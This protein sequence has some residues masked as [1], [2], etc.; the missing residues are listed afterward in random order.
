MLVSEC[1]VERAYPAHQGLISLR[2]VYR[3]FQIF[4][5]TYEHSRSKS[6]NTYITNRNRKF[7]KKTNYLSITLHLAF[8]DNNGL[9]GA[10]G[11]LILQA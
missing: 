7:K 5:L 4:T 11:H 10:K 9:W 2:E 1:P 6:A 3:F 8:V